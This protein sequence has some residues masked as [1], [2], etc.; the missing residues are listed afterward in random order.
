[1]IVHE[2]IKYIDPSIGDKRTQSFININTLI[3]QRFLDRINML[4]DLPAVYDV[5]L[6]TKF[7]AILLWTLSLNLQG[8]V[9]V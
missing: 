3:L 8:A 1:M 6:T 2:K 7:R 9:S 5:T 4:R